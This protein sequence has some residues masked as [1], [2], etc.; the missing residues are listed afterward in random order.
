MR[1][2]ICDD[3]RFFVS[4]ITQKIRN[5]ISATNF[6][7]ISITTFLSMKPLLESA[8]Q[9]DIFFLDV[10]LDDINGIEGAREILSIVPNALITYISSYVEFAPAGYE[11]NAYR[12]LLKSDLDKTFDSCLSGMLRIY[13]ERQDFLV[14]K[15]N[16]EHIKLSLKKIV[17]IESHKRTVELHVTADLKRKLVYY[18]KLSRLEAELSSK[19]FLRI[20]KSYLV[21]MRHIVKIKNYIAYLD[22]NTSLKVSIQNYQQILDNFILWKGNN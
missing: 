17:F 3:D 2:A 6:L 21:N 19:G 22:N 5:Y 11:V 4:A 15:T 7:D 10:S 1:I 18:D 8:K 20:Q 14:F 13:N 9:F 16:S 12:Y